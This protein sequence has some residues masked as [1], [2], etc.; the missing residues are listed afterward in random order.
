MLG[1]KKAESLKEYIPHLIVLFDKHQ[2]LIEQTLSDW[3]NIDSSTQPGQ[4]KN[5]A[6]KNALNSLAAT[7]VPSFL[8][9]NFKVQ[10]PTPY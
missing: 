4:Q 5:N 9:E 7:I 8:G 6:K 3:K 1:Q 10:I 2:K